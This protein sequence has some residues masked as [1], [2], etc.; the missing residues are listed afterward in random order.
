MNDPENKLEAPP[1]SRPLMIVID[2]AAELLMHHAELAASAT[3]ATANGLAD[4]AGV[5]PAVAEEI[6]LSLVRQHE[7]H[8]Q[9][10]RQLAAAASDQPDHDGEE[11]MHTAGSW[12]L[13]LSVFGRPLRAIC[14]ASLVEDDIPP[15]QPCLDCDRR[16][17]RSGAGL[18]ALLLVTLV[19]AVMVGLDAH[20]EGRSTSLLIA[21]GGAIASL[22]GL[23]RGAYLWL[24]GAWR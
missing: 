14:G 7:G 21:A 2:E 23:G 3:W 22:A 16:L 20:Q 9:A 19:A 12:G 8:L 15:G 13:L 11:V 10:M 18:I 5:A 24:S 17:Q 4:P 6:R 1:T